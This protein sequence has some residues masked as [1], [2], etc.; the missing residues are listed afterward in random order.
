MADTA[1]DTTQDPMALLEDVQRRV[2]EIRDR[3]EHDPGFDVVDPDA[4]PAYL[5]EEQGEAHAPG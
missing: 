2:T 5:T 3:I 4:V 1:T